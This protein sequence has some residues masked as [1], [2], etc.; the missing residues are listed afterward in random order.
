MHVLQLAT[1]PLLQ[2]LQLDVLGV[3]RLEL[4]LGFLQAGRQLA[5]VLL[6]LLSPAEKR[7]AVRAVGEL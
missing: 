7:L 1:E 2:L 3:E 4:L 5:A 6:Q